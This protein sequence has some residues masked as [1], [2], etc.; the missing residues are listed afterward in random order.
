MQEFHCTERKIYLS[1]TSYWRKF[2]QFPILSIIYFKAINICLGTYVCLFLKDRFLREVLLGRVYTIKTF[3]DIAKLP[4]LKSGTNLDFHQYGTKVPIFSY[5]YQWFLT[6]A[7][8][9]KGD[10]VFS[11]CS[12]VIVKETEYRFLTSLPIF[13]SSCVQQM[14]RS[15][16]HFQVS[17]LSLIYSFSYWFIGPLFILKKP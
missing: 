15:L 5:S 8:L 7:N 10:V 16:S 11:M 1:I 9:Q 6:L 2:R 14:F 3:I 12:C 4:F 17:F 13:I